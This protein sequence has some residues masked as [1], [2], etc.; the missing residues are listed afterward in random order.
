MEQDLVTDSSGL[1]WTLL[2]NAVGNYFGTGLNHEGQKYEA[3]CRLNQ[4][5]PN[6]LMTVKSQAKGMQGEIFHD[7]LSWIGRDIAGLLTLFVNSN[8]H[9]GITPHIFNRIEETQDG[10]KKVIFRFGNPA[11]TRNFREEVTF[12]IHTNYNIEHIYAWGLPG[13]KFETRSGARMKKIF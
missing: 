5:I 9:P 6:K 2:T 4:E 1:A 13:G 3:E 8:N 7:E 11:D 12:S 10:S